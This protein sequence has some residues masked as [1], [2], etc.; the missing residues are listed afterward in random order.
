MWRGGR[1]M[2]SQGY[3]RVKLYSDDFF[4]SMVDNKGYVLE[5]RLLMAKHLG[6]CLHLWEIV[7]HKGTKYPKGS[8]EN[9]ADNRLENLQL[10]SED[11]HNQLTRL[12]SKIIWQAQQIKELK[13]ALT[14]LRS[15]GYAAALN[16]G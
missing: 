4:Y 15:A 9:R 8:R 14:K 1:E 3:I 12:E 16:S 6:R 11:R 5:H 10:V 13:L 7:H 2:T